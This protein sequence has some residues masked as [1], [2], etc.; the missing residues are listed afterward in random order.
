MKI[1]CSDSL[2]CEKICCLEI[3]P[4][5]KMLTSSGFPKRVINYPPVGFPAC[6]VSS[7]LT[8]WS[9]DQTS[10][11]ISTVSVLGSIKVKFFMNFLSLYVE[12]SSILL[13]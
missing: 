6:Q 2:R 8:F 12:I 10:H 3:L 13:P 5:N 4:S 9:L 7:V 1:N 11:D